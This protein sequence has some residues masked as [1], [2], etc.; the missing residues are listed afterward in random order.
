MLLL[1]VTVKTIVVEK[2]TV[3]KEFSVTV[4]VRVY[5]PTAAEGSTTNV[6]N[7]L[8]SSFVSV[9]PEPPDISNLAVQV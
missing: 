1:S 8:M 9:M 2:I 6:K 7:L 4:R 5:G 3:L